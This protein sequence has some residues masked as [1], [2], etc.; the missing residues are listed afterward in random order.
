MGQPRLWT[1]EW[2]TARSPI[3][4]HIPA[5]PSPHDPRRRGSRRL[6]LGAHMT[7]ETRAQHLR[8]DVQ[9]L[10]DRAAILDCIAPTPWLRPPRRRAA[11]QHLPRRRRRRARHDDQPGPRVR[12]VGER[13][14]AATSDDICTT[15]RPTP[16]RSTATRPTPRATCSS[17]LLARRQTATV[18]CGRYST[19][20]SVAMASGG[21]RSVERP[22][23][24]RSP[25]TLVVQLPGTSRTRATSRARASANRHTHDRS[26]S[27][28]PSR[29][30]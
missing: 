26:R 11:H 22:S 30:W 10:K 14:H 18:M 5:A 2:R 6:N 9:Y 19:A 4:V 8:R 20:S 16:A 23:S 7:V 28:Q 15:S 13:V 3:R 27:R 24:S 21:S 29:W 25:P 12:R 1:P 17:P